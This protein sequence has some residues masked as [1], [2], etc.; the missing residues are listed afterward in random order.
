MASASAG[1]SPRRFASERWA[2]SGPLP[3]HVREGQMR[4]RGAYPRPAGCVA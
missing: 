1:P 3:H 4:W 2:D